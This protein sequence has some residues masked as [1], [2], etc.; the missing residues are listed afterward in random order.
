MPCDR[1]KGREGFFSFDGEEGTNSDTK[2][3]KK[4][5]GEK[6]GAM[7]LIQEQFLWGEKGKSVVRGHGLSNPSYQRGGGEGGKRKGEREP[8]RVQFG[9]KIEPCFGGGKKLALPVLTK[10]EESELTAG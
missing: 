4:G 9:E 10:R 3:K 2:E 7:F 8:L 6:K 1:K 5:G